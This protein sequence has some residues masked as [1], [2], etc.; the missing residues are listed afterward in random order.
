MSDPATPP[1]DAPVLPPGIPEDWRLDVDLS[2]P[3]C[4][5]NLRALRMP[6]CP[7][8]GGVFRWQ[9][10]LGLCCPRCGERL[11]AVDGDACPVCSVPLN[12]QLLLESA[13]PRH[14]DQTY[15]YQDRPLRAMLGTW[16]TVR[17]PR[18]FWERIPIE[19]PPNVHRLR[20]YLG[21]ALALG[22]LTVFGPLAVAWFQYSQSGQLTLVRLLYNSLWGW[23]AVCAIGTLLPVLTMAG[24]P[25][26][27][28]TMTRFRIRRDQL[29][30]CAAYG[31]TPLIWAAFVMTFGAVLI[32]LSFRLA[33][34]V[35]APPGL[36]PVGWWPQLFDIDWLLACL[37]GGGRWLGLEVYDLPYWLNLL[38]VVLLAHGGVLWCWRF[39][40]VALRGYLRLDRRNAWALL[41]STQ[42]IGVLALLLRGAGS[43]GSSGTG[44]PRRACSHLPALGADALRGRATGG[45]RA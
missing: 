9:A 3:A 41:L 14:A 2:C 45:P 35:T 18:R 28:P 43:C 26:F 7:E 34:L 42:T 10:L 32:E 19:L 5:Y 16:W 24:L 15:E 22:L 37:A 30:R 11:G 6:R 20:W 17:R 38:V 4:R 44:W 40:Y 8:C 25:F 1:S 29:L 21:V 36:A 39:T 27:A 31:C 23:L 33:R 13:Q 12:W